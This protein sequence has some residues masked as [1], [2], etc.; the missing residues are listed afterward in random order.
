M[1]ILAGTIINSVRDA[2]PDPTYSAG[3]PQPDADGGL[4]R[5][6][7]MYRWLDEGARSMTARMGYTL[8]DWTALPTVASQPV[9][10]V[11]GLFSLIDEVYHKQLK[12]RLRQ[13]GEVDEIYPGRTPAAQASAA[14]V[15]RMTDHI[16]VGFDPMPSAADPATTL[17]GGITASDA[18]IVL[19]SATGFLSFGYVLIGTELIQYGGISGN[20]LIGCRR[21]LGG[22]TA[23]SHLTAVAVTQCSLW[24]KGTRSP[25]AIADSTSVV[26]MPPAWVPL[27]N[28]YVLAQCR[29]MEQEF[30]E[31][32]RLLA[33]WDMACKGIERSFSGIDPFVRGRPAR[34]D[35]VVLPSAQPA[36]AQTGG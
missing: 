6:S 18:S 7:T 23:V 15:Y 10:A 12:L 5:A 25:L 28:L 4:F 22:T 26:E 35:G 3:V 9:Y 31:A 24:L 27:L 17:N 20:T 19:T 29:T 34:P 32:Q 13:H 33:Q 30:G 16:E 36:Q 8:T 2:I 1:T 21:G 14:Y 11:D